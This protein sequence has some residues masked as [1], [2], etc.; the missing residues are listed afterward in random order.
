LLVLVLAIWML[1]W[2]ITYALLGS[3]DLLGLVLVFVGHC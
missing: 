1:T 2:V 3:C